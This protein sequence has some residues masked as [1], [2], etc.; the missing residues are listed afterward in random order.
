MSRTLGGFL[1]VKDGTKYDYCFKESVESLLEFC[2]K[3]AVIY[4]ESSDNTF[5]ILKEIQ[6]GNS[7]LVLG[8]V[9]KDAWEK[10]RGKEKLAIFQNYAIE[11]L[12]TDY[13]YLQQAD[14]ITHESCYDT[15]R[16]AMKTDMEGFLI[17][18]I[19][20]WGD[21][22]HQLNVPQYRKPCSTEVIRLTKRGHPTYGD[23]ESINAQAVDW[24]VK[25]I[26]M[27]HYGFVRDRKIQPDKIREMQGN[28]F[29]CGV[30]KKLDGMVEFD[31]TKW[32]GPEDLKPIDFTH[33]KII[34]NWVDARM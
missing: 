31:G 5:D 28:I 24:F 3:V 14:E 19:N 2:D 4:V 33:P 18:R 15:I 29:E 12:D 20:L 11:L 1:F 10:H 23:G 8:G 25:S 22:M 16:Q 32:F 27:V 9:T 26:F 30:D 7:R 13:Q 21:P 17:S 34:Q 6:L